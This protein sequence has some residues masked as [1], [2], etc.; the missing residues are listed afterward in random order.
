MKKVVVFLLLIICLVFPIQQISAHSGVLKKS[1]D[2]FVTFYQSPL[3]PLVGEEVKITFV[4]TDA[5]YKP[6]ENLHGTLKLIDTFYGNESKDKIILTKPFI[7]DDNGA[8]ELAYTFTKQNFFSLELQLAGYEEKWQHIDYL[9][10][11]RQAG[12]PII[13]TKKTEKNSN[14]LLFLLGSIVTFGIMR[15]LQIKS[16]TSPKVKNNTHKKRQETTEL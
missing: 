14:I 5:E 11:P 16:V 10:Q 13:E 2:I 4:V 9:I 7:T 8:S 3:S 15:I 6:H 12:L 1:G